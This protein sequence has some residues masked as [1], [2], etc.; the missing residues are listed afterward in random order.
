MIGSEDATDS[1]RCGYTRDVAGLD[2]V[3]AVCCW[4]PVW[5]NRRRCV[6]HANVR[7]KPVEV[8]L[9]GRPEP[10]ERLDGAMLR[11]AALVDVDWLAGCRLIAADFDGATLRGSDLS[12]ADLR[13]ASFQ[14]ADLHGTT[15]AGTNVENAD[16]REA[17]LRGSDLRDARMY[18]TLFGG[19]LINNDTTLDEEVVYEREAAASD[20]LDLHEIGDAI[21][22]TYRAF[23]RLYEENALHDRRDHYYRQEQD[24]RRRIAWR[25]GEYALALRQEGSRWVMR[26]G[27]SP[28][29]VL[30]TQLVVILLCAAFFPLSGGIQETAGE[31]AVTFRVEDPT[32]ASQYWLL[33]V[34]FKSLYFSVITFATLG[35]GDIQPIGFWAR[36]IAGTEALL[37]VLLMALLVF[38]LTR[39]VQ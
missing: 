30:V 2:D 10:G 22:W 8:L 16:L 24:A 14:G 32:T 18:R 25:R 5:E 19:A 15:L 35:Y 12:D 4:R 38:V 37:G 17:D 21:V 26:Y 31:Q 27:T 7:E 23:Q 6:W 11:E 20:E 9:E 1:E 39:S 33:R 29:R 3:G 34:F 13:G 28:W 36:M